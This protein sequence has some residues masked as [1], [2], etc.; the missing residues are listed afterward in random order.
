MFS[1][2]PRD[3]RLR[4]SL[5]H[6]ARRLRVQSPG[7]RA[8]G[9]PRTAVLP[10]VPDLSHLDDDANC[11]VAQQFDDDWTNILFV[12]RVIANKKSRT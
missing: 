2:T 11:I 4:R 9:F 12:G 8:L 7:P 6:G 5:R 10:V 1:R 3:P